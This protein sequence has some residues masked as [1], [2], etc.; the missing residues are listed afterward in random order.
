MNPDEFYRAHRGLIAAE[1]CTKLPTA[2][3]APL[4][5]NFSQLPASIK[6]YDVA[7]DDL[8]RI[9]DFTAKIEGLSPLSMQVLGAM[10][11][12]GHDPLACQYTLTIDR[13]LMASCVENDWHMDEEIRY[14]EYHRNILDGSKKV[15][16]IVTNKWPTSTLS[17][18]SLSECPQ[19]VDRTLYFLCVLKGVVGSDIRFAWQR[20]LKSF[21]ERC[22]NKENIREFAAQ[23]H[24]YGKE[25]KRQRV[26]PAEDHVIYFNHVM[27]H[28]YT[29]QF[30]HDEPPPPGAELRHRVMLD[31]SLQ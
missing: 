23:F 7:F 5:I 24:R 2:C 26:V 16:T 30:V 21:G 22:P 4:V 20:A 27:P 8:F 9:Q 19:G 10:D 13:H 11:A 25:L 1:D 15:K 28:A 12:G 18:G 29:C 31:V 14:R 17:L 3:I 6:F